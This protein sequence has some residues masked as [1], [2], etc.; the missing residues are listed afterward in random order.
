M[1]EARAEVTQAAGAR[2]RSRRRGDGGGRDCGK[3]WRRAG[4]HVYIE[5]AIQATGNEQ[6]SSGG[7]EGQ[8]VAFDRRRTARPLQRASQGLKQS[9]SASASAEM[10]PMQVERAAK[11]RV[12]QTRGGRQRASI[13]QREAQ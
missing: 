5:G 4:E 2:L 1:P 8:L 7:G 11:P 6:T 12:E 9:A 10:G 3:C 13:E